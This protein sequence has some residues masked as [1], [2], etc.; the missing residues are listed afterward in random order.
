MNDMRCRAHIVEIDYKAHALGQR[1]G[2]V[3]EGSRP[4]SQGHPAWGGTEGLFGLLRKKLM[5]HR[6]ADQTCQAKALCFFAEQRP[7]LLQKVMMP[8]F[9]A[10]DGVARLRD[11]LQIWPLQSMMT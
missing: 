9:L 2:H 6:V 10:D 3:V 11:C 1:L 5:G 7:H 4:Q 8:A